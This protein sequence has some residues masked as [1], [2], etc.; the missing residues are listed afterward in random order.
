MAPRSRSFTQRIRD[1]LGFS[2]VAVLILF[3]AL[4]FLGVRSPVSSIFLSIL[5]TIALNVGLSYWGE[6][7]AR[8]AREDA[9]I[10]RGRSAARGGGD[11][12]WRDDRR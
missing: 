1:H 2:I 4:R 5:V 8:R 3:V 6:H 7:R 9:L 12:R 10:A 11:I